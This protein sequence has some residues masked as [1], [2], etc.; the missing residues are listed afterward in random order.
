MDIFGRGI[1]LVTGASQQLD[2]HSPFSKDDRNTWKKA[3]ASKQIGFHA[4]S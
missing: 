4:L 2:P 3:V 1:I